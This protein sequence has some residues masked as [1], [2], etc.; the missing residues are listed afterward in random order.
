[1]LSGRVPFPNWQ[2]AR[3]EHGFILEDS[4]S[5]E[6]FIWPLNCCLALRSFK[7]SFDLAAMCAC[8]LGNTLWVS[9]YKSIQFG[10][11]ILRCYHSCLGVACGKQSP[12]WYFDLQAGQ[13]Q[14][15]HNFI[16]TARLLIALQVWLDS[17]QCKAFQNRW[18]VCWA[19]TFYQVIEDS[20]W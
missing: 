7:S 2:D 18:Y 13:K 12:I 14:V 1:M 3:C 8:R 17:S 19:N 11:G 9:G 5:L 15:T 16:L 4:Y 20:C 6:A 10:L